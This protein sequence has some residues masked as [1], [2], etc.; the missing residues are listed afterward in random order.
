[1][2]YIALTVAFLFVLGSVMWLRP[3]PTDKR[4]ASLRQTA[5]SQGLRVNW[6]PAKETAWLLQPSK[7][8][9]R[10]AYLRQTPKQGLLLLRWRRQE[11]G[12][13]PISHTTPLPAETEW[14]ACISA[15]EFTAH[16]CAVIWS[17]EGS[18]EDVKQ[19]AQLLKQAALQ[20]N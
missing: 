15:L 17:E 3:S 2:L 1:M 4:L 11:D 19:I 16:D 12:W 10:Y 14:P 18:E 6:L 9:I 8:W 20:K 13:Q 7:K 5:V